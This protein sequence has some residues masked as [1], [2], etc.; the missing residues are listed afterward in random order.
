M[1]FEVAKRTGIRRNSGVK[2]VGCSSGKRQLLG[3][4]EIVNDLARRWCNGIDVNQVTISG[5]AGVMIDVDPLVGAP[6]R[7]KCGAQALLTGRIQT[8]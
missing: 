4:D 1:V 3:A 8:R 5:I 7:M 2:R 6:N